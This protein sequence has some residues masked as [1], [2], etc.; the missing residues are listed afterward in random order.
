MRFNHADD[1]LSQ[2]D[3]VQSE[4]TSGVHDETAA[5]GNTS[6]S[7][8]ADI[9]T[10]QLRVIDDLPPMPEAHSRRSTMSRRSH[11]EVMIILELARYQFALAYIVVLL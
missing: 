11:S 4:T 8:P 6:Q 1:I 10:R 3:G 7:S 5:I 2:H 9:R